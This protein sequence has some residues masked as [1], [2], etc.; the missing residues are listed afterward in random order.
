VAFGWR[1]VKGVSGRGA[2]WK[3]IT[4]P[5]QA[6]VWVA[7]ML[8]LFL[9]IVGL[10]ID[11]GIVFDAR[12]EI[13]NVADGAARA[14]ATQID[15]QTYRASSG[16]T[17]VLDQR[18]AQQAAAA[19]VANGGSALTASVSTDSQHVIVTVSR[20]VQP[21]FL[22]IVGMTSVQVSTMATAE[23]QHGIAQGTTG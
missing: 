6:I 4:Y 5:G 8:P 16:Q 9:A 10:A 1:L 23:V 7:V 3:R 13:Q 2:N 14:G 18:S 12:R 19:Y 21:S 11:G 15:E 17:I 22:R 20:T